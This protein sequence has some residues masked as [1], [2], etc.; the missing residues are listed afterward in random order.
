[1]T[2]KQKTAKAK[3]EPKEEVTIVTYSWW[4]AWRTI[5]V[6]S[7]AAVAALGGAFYGIKQLPSGTPDYVVRDV[8][9]SAIVEGAVGTIPA[10]MIVVD[11]TAVKMP[12]NV[13]GSIEIG[14]DRS[15]NIV[16]ESKEEAYLRN[17]KPM[18][19]EICLK[20]TAITELEGNILTAYT[21][22]LDI[23]PEAYCDVLNKFLNK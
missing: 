18:V 11:N 9:L 13:G 15:V 3:S 8:Q 22:G 16:G 17:L 6:G 4:Y 5:I 21:E 7:L 20:E 2:S 12:D 23:T 1:M 19:T 14:E 10:G